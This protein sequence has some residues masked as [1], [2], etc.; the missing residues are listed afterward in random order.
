M[1]LAGSIKPKDLIGIPWQL[2][3]ALREDGWFLR[4]DI[5]WAKRNPMPES[6]TDRCTRSHEYVFLFSKNARYSFDQEALREPASCQRGPGNLRSVRRLPGECP[7]ER[8]GL[9]AN[10]HRIGPRA[11]RNRRDVWAIASR[12]FTGHHFAVFPEELV[13]LCLLAASRPGETVLDPF[14]GSGTT[15]Q[16]AI[17]LE[18]HFIGCELNAAYRSLFSTNERSYP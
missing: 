10:L 1:S 17:R 7:G 2:A 15:G 9:G 6:V 4:Q 5:I 3:F 8:N 16:V 18:R 11:M 14:L 13:T 12:P